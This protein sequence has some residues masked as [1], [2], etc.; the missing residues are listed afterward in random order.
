V[1]SEAE[2][3]YERALS[4]LSE[5]ERNAVIMKVEF[6]LSYEEI[7]RALGKPSVGAARMT[8]SRALARLAERA[9]VPFTAFSSKGRSAID[10]V[11]REGA[12]MRLTERRFGVA[13]V[14]DLHGALSGSPASELLQ[15]AVRD[16]VHKGSSVLVLSLVE[17]TA[18]DQEGLDTLSGVLGSV[19]ESDAE[20]RI[21]GQV[22]H[23]KELGVMAHIAGR[24]GMFETVDE[25]LADVRAALEVRQS[26]L[27]QHPLRARLRGLCDRLLGRRA[28][29]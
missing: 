16:Q 14:V 12:P 7:T 19:R 29:P 27:Q 13:A 26:R 28:G 6:D 1:G 4:E 18:V 8:V 5:Q 9:S 21:A 10:T 15:L 20:L 22:E 11:F 24:V 25:A 23:L 3:R 2:E 17:V